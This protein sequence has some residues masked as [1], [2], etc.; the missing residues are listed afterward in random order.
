VFQK[1]RNPFAP[2][3]PKKRRATAG[4]DF[5][6]RKERSDPQSAHQCPLPGRRSPVRIL[7]LLED[8]RSQN[9]KAKLPAFILTYELQEIQFFAIT[10]AKKGYGGRMVDAVMRAL[11]VDWKAVVLMGWDWSDGFWEHMGG[12]Y[13][14]LEIV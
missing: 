1:G 14:N 2:D 6:G 5:D 11:P 13:A 4:K 9:F 7:I 3:N 12:K 8:T 10:S